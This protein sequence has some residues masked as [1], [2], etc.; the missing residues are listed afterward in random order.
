MS[1]VVETVDVAVPV[2]TAY[3]QWTQ[4]EQF[5]AFMNSVREIRQLDDTRLH[6]V[7]E[8]GGVRREFDARI[9]EQHPDERVAWTSTEGPKHAGVVTFHRLDD[10]HSRVTAQLDIDPEGFVENV[11]D[12]VGIVDRLVKSDM[13]KF[14]E[15]IEQRGA[16]TGA[17]RG[18]VEQPD[19]AGFGAV[20]KPGSWISPG[21]TPPGAAVRSSDAVQ[22]APDLTQSTD[23]HRMPDPDDSRHAI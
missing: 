17:W 12:K 13:A 7:V 15:F 21:S 20:P 4:F 19:A 14:R 22:A 10:T 2:R 23:V 3:N 6:W 9:T 5:P 18:D 11:A 8:F 1:Q 16:E